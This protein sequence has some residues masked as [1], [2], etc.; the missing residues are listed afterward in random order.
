MK[1]IISTVLVV[2]MVE[3]A[4]GENAP[5]ARAVEDASHSGMTMLLE[6]LRAHC[7]KA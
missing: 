5:A 1:S 6:R 4:A 3:S 7:S 2:T